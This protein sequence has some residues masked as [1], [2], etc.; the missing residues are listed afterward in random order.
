MDINEFFGPNRN[1]PTHP[2]FWR[3]SETILSYDGAID[4]AV[5][6][7]KFWEDAV[8][9]VIDRNSVMYM[10]FQ[11]AARACQAETVGDIV[12][13]IEFIT[14]ATVL[15]IEGFLMGVEFQKRGGKQDA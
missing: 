12:Q 14:K 13:N 9:A 2:D 7:D 6:K 15:Y 4:E 11:R 10:A 3:L 1:R 8:D 5:D